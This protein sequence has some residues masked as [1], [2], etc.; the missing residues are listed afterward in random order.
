MSLVL[1]NVASSNGTPGNNDNNNNADNT[2]D[3]SNTVTIYRCRAPIASLDCMEEFSGTGGQIDFGRSISLGSNPGLPIRHCTSATP[4]LRYK[5]LGKSGLRVSNVGLGTWP[6]FAPSVSEE[7]AETII[8]LAVDSGINLFDLSEAHSGI[9]AEIELGKILQKY[10]WK[11][12]SYVVTTKIYWS[13]KSDERGLSRKHII[14]SVQASLARLQL[15]Y[16]DIVIIHKADSMCPMEEIVRAMTYVISQGW[17]MYWGTARW[18]PTEIM[19]AYTNCRQ[20]NCVTPI[21]EQAEYHMFYR[22]KAELYL[23]E[24]YNKIG[25]GLMAWGP[26]GMCLGE[27]QNGER[28]L[29]PKGSFKAKSHSYSW[30]E[31][32]LNKEERLEEGRRHCDKVRDLANLAEKLGCSATQLSIAWSLKHEPVQ[33]L[34]LGATSPE[35]LHQSLQALQLLPRL[36]TGVML[37]IERILDNK[38]IH[39]SSTSS[40][41]DNIKYIRVST[42]N[43]D[44]KS[45][46]LLLSTS[47]SQQIPIINTRLDS[48]SNN[49]YTI[50]NLDTINEQQQQQQQQQKQQQQQPNARQLDRN[51]SI[52][53]IKPQVPGTENGKNSDKIRRN[54]SLM[55]FR[56][57]DISLKSIYASLKGNKSDKEKTSKN[58]VTTITTNNDSVNTSTASIRKAP[59]LKIDTVDQDET[60]TL[61]IYPQS[62]GGSTQHRRSFDTNSSAFLSTHQYTEFS[63]SRVSSP[64]LCVSAQN[65]RRSSTSDIIGNKRG[66]SGSHSAAESRRPSTSDLLRRARERKGSEGRLG[67]SISHGCVNR[68]GG[69]RNRRTSMAY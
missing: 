18:S 54:S 30:T 57:L 26:L 63:Q 43:N 59:F 39:K 9:R 34:L 56:S 62:P 44:L 11:R 61:L 5:N 50:S 1:C 60:Q 58:D 41:K 7:Q 14:E 45:P 3:D 22:E 8:K 68:G 46:L 53:S 49:N 31:D 10:Q 42:S 24:L 65:I 37:E 12:A 2:S 67:R 48:N 55:N 16:I 40:S 35:Q 69:M 64:Y 23:P 13:T 6:I 33:S 28:L 21:V 27:T 4:G 51:K 25:V 32:E 36:S 15:A 17:A 38:P 52:D 47:V 19:E 66:G 20:F 29:F